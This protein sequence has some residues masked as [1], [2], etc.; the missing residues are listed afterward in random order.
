MVYSNSNTNFKYFSIQLVYKTL[1]QYKGSKYPD[2]Y[3]IIGIF[4]FRISRMKMSVY[5]N[6]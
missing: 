6:W 5:K 4:L 1:N 2:F 3:K